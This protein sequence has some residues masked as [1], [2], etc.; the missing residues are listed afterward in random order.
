[1]PTDFVDLGIR[2]LTFGHPSMLFV[3]AIAFNLIVC[4]EKFHSRATSNPLA[5]ASR[6]IDKLEHRYNRTEMSASMRRTDGI[7]TTIFLIVVSLLAGLLADG[8]TI[9]VPFAWI[10]TAILAGTLLSIRTYL[11]RSAATIA[12]L[13]AAPI[14]GKATMALLTGRDTTKL[15]G[16]EVARIGV[17]YTARSLNEGVVAAAFYFFL[18]GLG[19]FFVYGVIAITAQL[20][21]ECSEWTRDFGWAPTRAHEIL[22][23]PV[24][25]VSAVLISLA[26]A[27]ISISSAGAVLGSAFGGGASIRNWASR[28]SVAAMAGALGLRL[29]R[30]PCVMDLEEINLS[31]GKDKTPPDTDHFAGA[32]QIY[33]TVTFLI[34]MLALILTSMKVDLPLTYWLFF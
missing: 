30:A 4:N 17:E 24:N 22:V 12:G 27:P 31:V 15:D 3:L 2:Q 26:T 28:P 20:L 23:W 9:L 29:D 21:E 33:V 18:F 7:S 19:G 11:D 10:L 16:A 1:M 32:R 6:I 25:Y 14:Q 34:A 13:E 8:A 5:W